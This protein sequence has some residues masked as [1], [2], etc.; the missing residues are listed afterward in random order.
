MLWREV[1][2]GCE[3]EPRNLRSVANGFADLPCGALREIPIEFTG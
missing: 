2:N 1:V 3:S